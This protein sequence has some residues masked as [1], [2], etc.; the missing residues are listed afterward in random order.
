MTSPSAGDYYIF[1]NNWQSSAAATDQFSVTYTVIDAKPSDAFE[2]DYIGSNEDFELAVE[3][4]T[5]LV[6]GDIARSMLTFTSSDT[7]IA[8]ISIPF[9]LHL[10]EEVII[11]NEQVIASEVQP[12]NTTAFNINIAANHTNRDRKYIVT[13]TI[14]AGHEYDDILEQMPTSINSSYLS[15]ATA[16]AAPSNGSTDTKTTITW[17]VDVPALSVPQSLGFKFTP[18]KAGQDFEIS[19]D[20]ANQDGAELS[21]QV[22]TFD[23]E[24]VAPVV[25]LQAPTTAQE[26]ETVTLSTEGTY[27][28]NNEAL[29]YLWELEAADDVTVDFNATDS[30]ISFI[31]PKTEADSQE[32]LFT[33]TITDEKW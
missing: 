3:W 25:M 11:P 9:A 32:L 4:D 31:A 28:G 10:I 19:I 15:L 14:P 1:V 12:G 21:S 22:Y 18:I 33:V 20:V 26:G 6:I 23:V 7:N 30:N 29:T 8:P 24:D 27:E 5:D 2:A 13:A 16:G 17:E